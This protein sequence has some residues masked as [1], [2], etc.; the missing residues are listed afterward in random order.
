MTIIET[1]K[2]PAAIGPYSQAIKVGNLVYTSGQIPLVPSTGKIEAA[3]IA[4]QTEQAIQNLSEVL[5]ASG[6][7]LNSVVKT[8]CFLSDINHFAA[9]N[10]IYA[11]YFTGKP[12]RSC[13]EVSNLP[14]GALVEIEAVALCRAA[15]V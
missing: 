4:G 11:R 10:E 8:T 9:F 15:E 14:K 7:D 5:K 2:A 1:Q 3:D 13:V 12:A 6:S